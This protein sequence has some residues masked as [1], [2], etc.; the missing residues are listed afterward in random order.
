MVG[1]ERSHSEVH[2][3]DRGIEQNS[4]RDHRDPLTEGGGGFPCFILLSPFLVDEG[5]VESPAWLW[6]VPFVTRS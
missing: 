6:F 5:V 3:W 1:L 4:L 2:A